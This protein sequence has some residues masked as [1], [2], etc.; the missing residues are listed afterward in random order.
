MLLNAEP[1]MVVVGE[2]GDIPQAAEMI[3]LE[4]PDVVLLDVSMPRINGLEGLSILQHKSPQSRFLMLTM[5]DDENYLRQALSQ[6]ASGYVLKQA[7]NEELLSAIRVVFFGGTYLHQEHRDLFFDEG[8]QQEAPAKA[9][10]T[11]LNRLSPREGEILVLIAMGFTN[12]QAAEKLFLSEK[13]IETY[14]SR[15]MTKLGLHSRA[16]LVR[17]ALQCGLIKS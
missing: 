12:R 4:Q 13:T 7:A 10:K 5:H 8:G 1:D 15:L 16:D 11:L 3:A 14:K 2:A 9:D 17:Y 6:G